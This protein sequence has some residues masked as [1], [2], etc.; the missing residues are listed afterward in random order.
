[1][2]IDAEWTTAEALAD[3]LARLEEPHRQKKIDTVLALVDARLAGRSEETIWTRPEVC[4]RTTYH[5]KWKKDPVFA[6]VLKIATAA[7]RHYQN[8]R[9]ARA[10]AQA[11]DALALASPKAVG[12]LIRILDSMDD[13]DARL[14]AVAILDR[15]GLETAAKVETH[16]VTSSLDEWRQDAE[17]RRAAVADMLGAMDEPAGDPDAD[18]ADA[19]GQ[20]AEETA[21]A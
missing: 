10:I 15:A 14:A 3:Q 13:T 8:T 7:A 6:E 4:N 17:R 11:A 12:R 21:E 2:A 16:T 5:T 19:A 18:P 1:M 20:A 9:A